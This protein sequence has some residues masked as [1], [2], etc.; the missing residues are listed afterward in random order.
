M[1]FRHGERGRELTI[2][3]RVHIA[4]QLAEDTFNGMGMVQMLVKDLDDGIDTPVTTVEREPEIMAS[5]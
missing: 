1:W 5:S 2:G 4:F 3:Q